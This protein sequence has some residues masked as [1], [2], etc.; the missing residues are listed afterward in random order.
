MFVLCV[1]YSKVQKAKPGRSGQ[2]RTEKVETKKVPVGARFSTPMQ[3]G[4]GA[5][6][7]F[8]STVK[9]SLSRGLNNRDVALT[10]HPHLAPR[11]KKE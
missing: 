11:V 7:A 5:Y 4:P 6:P 8:S 3:K 9:G 10:T 2:R 1:L